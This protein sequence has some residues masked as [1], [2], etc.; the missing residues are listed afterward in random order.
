MFSGLCS[1]WLVPCRV[2][3][4]VGQHNDPYAPLVR[5]DPERGR[6]SLTV[7]CVTAGLFWRT[8]HCWIA[9]LSL[10]SITVERQGL[11]T[12]LSRF[13]VFLLFFKVHSPTVKNPLNH[14]KTLIESQRTTQLSK[15]LHMSLYLKLNK[16]VGTTTNPG[17]PKTSAL[18]WNQKNPER[19]QQTPESLNRTLQ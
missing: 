4:L 11:C 12:V 8:R 18:L 6:V 5:G 10:L 15:V 16:H 9:A 17:E 13:S 3:D 7:F 14:D 2:Q 1:C 19:T